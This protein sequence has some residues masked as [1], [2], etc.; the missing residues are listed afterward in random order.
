MATTVSE[1]GLKDMRALTEAIR[2]ARSEEVRAELLT[3][4]RAIY[5]G[6]RSHMTPKQRASLA[7]LQAA[8]VVPEDKPSGVVMCGPLPLR[9]P[10][11]VGNERRF[12]R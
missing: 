5:D 4:R 12:G 7:K 8:K 9:P 2:G 6:V 1:Q 11:M 3:W 10:G